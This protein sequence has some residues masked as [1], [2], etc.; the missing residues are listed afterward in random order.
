M[1][2][3][4]KFELMRKSRQRLDEREQTKQA[5]E[6]RERAMRVRENYERP[7]DAQYNREISE[8]YERQS[9]AHLANGYNASRP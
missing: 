1:N 5:Q 4:T 7:L 2:K 9:R 3:P 6:A 8:V